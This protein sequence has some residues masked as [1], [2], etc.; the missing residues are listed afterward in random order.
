MSELLGFVVKRGWRRLVGWVRVGLHSLLV[1][2]VAPPHSVCLPAAGAM[3]SLVPPHSAC[4]A[5]WC[6]PA[7]TDSHVRC[8]PAINPQ[9]AAAAPLVQ[10]QVSGAHRSPANVASR[11][12]AADIVCRGPLH[13]LDTRERFSVGEG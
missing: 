8:W 6:C 2:R 12:L 9:P 10:G 5:S 13:K 7:E 1:L 3:A 11:L 4:R